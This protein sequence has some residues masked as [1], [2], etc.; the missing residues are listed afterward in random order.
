MLEVMDALRFVRLRLAIHAL[1]LLQTFARRF[2]EIIGSLE[3]NSAIMDS[4]M[5]DA[6]HN[7]MARTHTGS[8][9]AEDGIGA[10]GVEDSVETATSLQL[11]VRTVMMVTQ[12][13]EM[14]AAATVE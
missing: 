8:A 4:Q 9:Q 13:Q 7:V 11:E 14:D 5:Q 10:L 3:M 2:A 6:T 12:T 1:R